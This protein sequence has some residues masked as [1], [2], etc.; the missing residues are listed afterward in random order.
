MT[1]AGSRICT[2]VMEIQD[3]FLSTPDLRLSPSD[4]VR[5]F[6]ADCI[7]CTAILDALVDASV[8]AQ[9]ED[10]VYESA[11]PQL[12]PHLQSRHTSAPARHPA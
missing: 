10:G 12:H 1:T 2:L 5:R 8:L 7:T 3:A 6:G 11:F 4:A 9:A